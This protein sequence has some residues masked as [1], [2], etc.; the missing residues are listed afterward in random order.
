MGIW[1]IDV[2][3]STGKWM[4]DLPSSF[5]QRIQISQHSSAYH[6]HLTWNLDGSSKVWLKCHGNC[7]FLEIVWR[8][9]IMFDHLTPLQRGTS[10]CLQ[11]ASCIP[12]FLTQPKQRK[13]SNILVIPSRFCFVDH[14][15]SKCMTMYDCKTPLGRVFS[16][17]LTSQLKLKLKKRCQSSMDLV[18]TGKPRGNHGVLPSNIGGIPVKFPI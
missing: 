12:S 13:P 16:Q 7:G 3:D 2:L 8:S 4:L 9:T 6:H 15:Q 5:S 11:G 18:F 17:V 1:D 10:R 14:I